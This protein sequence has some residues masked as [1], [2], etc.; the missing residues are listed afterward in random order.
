MVITFHVISG[1]GVTTSSQWL[2]QN[3]PPQL[4]QS[5]LPSMPLAM[6]GIVRM[7]LKKCEVYHQKYI[8]KWVI[9][10]TPNRQH[11]GLN[12]PIASIIPNLQK[13]FFSMSPSAP[14]TSDCHDLRTLAHRRRSAPHLRHLVSQAPQFWLELWSLVESLLA[15]RIKHSQLLRSSHLPRRLEWP[16]P[17]RNLSTECAGIL[18]YFSNFHI[19]SLI[20][21][22]IVIRS[23]QTFYFPC[24]SGFA[25]SQ[26]GQE[27]SCASLIYSGISRCKSTALALRICL[28]WAVCIVDGKSNEHLAMCWNMR[29][30]LPHVN[31]ISTGSK[32]EATHTTAD[33]GSSGHSTAII[34]ELK[35]SKDSSLWL[36]S[37]YKI[38][39]L[40]PAPG[41][42]THLFGPGHIWAT[43][44][45]D[46]IGTFKGYVVSWYPGFFR[47][48]FNGF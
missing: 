40:I 26:L 29:S 21:H 39:Q 43:D 41:K 1:G 12:T 10:S 36:Y 48:D 22:G 16:L 15:G 31:S 37:K 42:A 17:D 13:W 5:M 30:S 20:N 35:C 18:S 23:H 3:Q 34:P 44:D 6:G 25:S 46:G 47:M 27:F 14:S 8:A 2:P 28:Q 33:P 45:E 24:T 11:N 38:R 32:Q 19:W 4:P 7:I 9:A